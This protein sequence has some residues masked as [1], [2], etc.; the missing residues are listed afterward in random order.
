MV[1]TVAVDLIGVGLYRL[2]IKW[3]ESDDPN[4]TRRRLKLASFGIVLFFC[5][6]GFAHLG[7]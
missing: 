5:D 6:A 3:G 7:N 4:K 1:K 2:A